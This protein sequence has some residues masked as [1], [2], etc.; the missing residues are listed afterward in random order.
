[1]KHS[2]KMIAIY[3][4]FIMAFALQSCQKEDVISTDDE[5]AYAIASPDELVEVEVTDGTVDIDPILTLTSANGD[6][7]RRQ[8]KMGACKPRGHKNPL[9][10]EGHFKQLNLSDEQRTSIKALLVSHK[11]CIM[12]AR[13]AFLSANEEALAEAKAARKAIVAE[14]KAGTMTKEEAKTAMKAVNQGLRDLIAENGTKE[15]TKI[16]LKACFDSFDT[17]IEAILTAEQL[18]KWQDLKTK[19]PWR[20]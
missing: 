10:F 11:E 13:E 6:I 17:N 7:E 5:L 8:G 18:A 1:M 16:A 4:L 19:R 20:I 15:Q 3:G 9:R 12:S 2:I 14:V